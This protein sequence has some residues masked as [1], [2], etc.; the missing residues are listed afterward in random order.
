ML[1]CSIDIWECGG[2]KAAAPIGDKKVAVPVGGK[3]AAAPIGDKKAAVPI[4]DK[5]VAVPVG[6]KNRVECRGLRPLHPPTPPDVPF[7]VSG[8]WSHPRLFRASY[9][10]FLSGFRRR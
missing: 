4:G 8:G 3:K 1:F 5:K 2:K 6:G 9:R 10:A 7:S